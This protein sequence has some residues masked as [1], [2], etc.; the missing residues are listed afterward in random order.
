MTGV[1]GRGGGFA[2]R[3]RTLTGGS[4]GFYKAAFGL[5]AGREMDRRRFLK[6][7]LPATAAAVFASG[8][9]SLTEVRNAIL[10]GSSPKDEKLARKIRDRFIQER[11]PRDLYWIL[12]ER[13]E[14]GMSRAEVEQELGEPGERVWNIRQFTDGNDGLFRQTDK[15]YKWRPCVDG[16]SVH[17]GFRNGK[18]VNFDGESYREKLGDASRFEHA[19]FRGIGDGVGDDVGEGVGDGVG[20]DL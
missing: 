2:G 12:C 13:L 4:G 3:R 8:C 18:L 9:G 14:Q 16:T 6:T 7:V 19:A 11:D 5:S 10:W 20:D 1:C 15:F 17:L